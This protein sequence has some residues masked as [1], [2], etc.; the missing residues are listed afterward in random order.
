MK[1]FNNF[2]GLCQ[3]GG[4][5]T[6][7]LTHWTAYAI[8]GY[9]KKESIM[10]IRHLSLL[11]ALFVFVT[12]SLAAASAQGE[13]QIE[14]LGSESCPSPADESKLQESIDSLNRRGGLPPEERWFVHNNVIYLR[15]EISLGDE[16]YFKT[17]AAQVGDKLRRVN[18]I[19]AGG[20]IKAVISIG[21]YI[22][23]HNLSV[24]VAG[25]CGGSCANYLFG[26]AKHRVILADGFLGFLGTVTASFN[27][28]GGTMEEYIRVSRR[29]AREHLKES[30]P[31]R[32]PDEIN[33]MLSKLFNERT[34]HEIREAMAAEK[35]M[36]SFFGIPQSFFD[37]TSAKTTNDLGAWYLYPDKE[38]L[39][40]LGFSSVGKPN[41]C[42][43]YHLFKK[44]YRESAPE[45]VLIIRGVVN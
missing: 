25:L 3:Q 37:I 45:S 13:Y 44:Y 11:L 19:S 27:E 28:L 38:L 36:Y 40:S 12:T 34:L 26:F 35:R 23:K 4:G 24:E 18:V 39:S 17:L 43:A 8:T 6:F 29:A 22:H 10:K 14:T 2:D 16:D 32:G 9:E 31:N 30:Y 15:G 42:S 20:H 33:I 21:E 41:L 7:L 1:I 5:G